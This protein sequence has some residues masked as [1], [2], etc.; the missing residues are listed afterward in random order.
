M[1]KIG[2]LH[3]T[4]APYFEKLGY[5]F[6]RN[7][8]PSKCLNWQQF[9]FTNSSVKKASAIFSNNSLP[10]YYVL[11]KPP[12]PALHLPLFSSSHV[13]SLKQSTMSIN[14]QIITSS[15]HNPLLPS[16][17][18]SQTPLFYTHVAIAQPLLSPSPSLA[19]L[20]GWLHWFLVVHCICLSPLQMSQPPSYLPC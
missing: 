20:I 17:R 8:V 2:V 13:K 18:T 15:L 9:L 4:Q 3:S 5:I 16:I 11:I 12:P 14:L 10:S 6:Q 19:T 7:V 1:H